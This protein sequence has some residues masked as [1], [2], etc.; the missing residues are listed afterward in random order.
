MAQK[1]PT[2]SP[3]FVARQVSELGFIIAAPLV[4]LVML[5]HKIDVLL[6]Y[7]AVFVIIAIPLSIIISGIVIYKKIK[8]I[9]ELRD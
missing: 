7:K 2:L 9:S 3:W 1:K 5:G 6:G 8:L 4:V